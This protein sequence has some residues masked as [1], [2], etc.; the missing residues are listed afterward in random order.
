[1]ARRKG[2]ETS[3]EGEESEIRYKAKKVEGNRV[4]GEKSRRE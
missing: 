4:Q 2:Q 3:G 1:M